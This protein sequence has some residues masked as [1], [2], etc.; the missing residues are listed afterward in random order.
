MSTTIQVAKAADKNFSLRGAS[1][2]DGMLLLKE[3]LP[4]QDWKSDRVFPARSQLKERKETL[5]ANYLNALEQAPTF[6]GR[7]QQFDRL[8]A[9][10]ESL[11]VEYTTLK[12]PFKEICSAECYSV[13]EKGRE[14]LETAINDWVQREIPCTDHELLLQEYEKVNSATPP[15]WFQWLEPW[16][17]KF[18]KANWQDL[19]RKSIPSSLRS[20]PGLANLSLH[21]FSINGQES[22]AYFRH[23]TQLPVD[24]LKI[25]ANIPL[26]E[27]EKRQEASNEAFRLSCLNV[28]SQL[29]MSLDQQLAKRTDTK[30]PYE[31]V[32]LTQ[33]LLSPG[34]VAT[35]KSK[36]IS[37]ASDNDTQIYE[38]KEE[39]VRFLQRLLSKP[40]EYQE[41]LA[42]R[43]LKV[44]EDGSIEYKGHIFKKITLLS[45]NHPY[46]ILRRFGTYPE[47]TK[48][49]DLNTAQ[50]LAAVSRYL[51]PIAKREEMAPGNAEFLNLL[52][53]KFADCE[54]QGRV[55]EKD[56]KD[57]LAMFEKFGDDRTIKALFNKDTAKLLSAVKSLLSVPPGQGS[58]EMDDKR[59]RQ[60]LT[61]ALE[62][63]IVNCIGGTPWIACKSGKDRTGGASA[64]IDAA[65]I[66]YTQHGRYP[67]Y[68]DS[69]EERACYLQSLKTLFESGHHQAVASQ[70]APGAEGLVNPSTFL[71]GDMVLDMDKI[72][73]QT[74]LARL[75]K[76]KKSKLAE[77]TFNQ[78]IL[79]KALK[80]IKDK[81]RAKST[82]DFLGDWYRNWEVYFIEGISVR[83]LRSGKRFESEADVVKFIEEKLLYKV[84]DEDLKK[85]YLAQLVYAFHQ[86]GFSHVFGHLFSLSESKQNSLENGPANIH[87]RLGGNV[88]INFSPLENGIQVEEINTYGKKATEIIGGEIE[89]ISPQNGGYFYQTSSSISVMMR[90]NKDKHELFTEIHQA[91]V[92]CAD[93]RLKPIFFR[94]KTLLEVLID[95]FELLYKVLGL[96]HGGLIVGEGLHER[97]LPTNSNPKIGESGNSNDSAKQLIVSSPTPKTLPIVLGLALCERF[98]TEIIA[99]FTPWVESFLSV[100]DKT[101]TGKGMFFKLPAEE[102]HQGILGAIRPMICSGA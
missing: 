27:E 43:G 91:N 48:R 92:D 83:E 13:L 65:E 37:D 47:Q 56:K 34:S 44:T 98:F 51:L 3:Y 82:G 15:L 36:H 42:K 81:V 17:Q 46:N 10:Y 73:R 75:N 95:F 32:I 101:I 76:P 23:A 79:K 11:L 78:H 22:P 87:Y 4:E 24:L 19:S 2:K 77:E 26:E 40:Q 41:S 63:I 45:T 39:V 70:N 90:K 99:L 38:M 35:L 67:R 80:E 21:K 96:K 86:G 7:K 55:S 14:D 31:A 100:K 68:H 1:Y 53:A 29:R 6:K 60:S 12:G 8:F 57:L 62:V 97:G 16:Q 94:E 85:D 54:L 66:F 5:Y 72:N 28:A 20:I 50:M 52:I 58:F 93:E 25:L 9:K 84:G 18:F 74:Q 89:E 64:A 49:N 102:Q 88:Q 33:S 59:H 30:K 69:Q 71:P 61:S